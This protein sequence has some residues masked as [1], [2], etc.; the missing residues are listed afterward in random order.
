MAVMLKV[1]E[2]EG[3]KGLL[4]GAARTSHD[5]KLSFVQMEYQMRPS[6]T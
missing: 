1:R 5:M 3:V 4:N 6:L 2:G